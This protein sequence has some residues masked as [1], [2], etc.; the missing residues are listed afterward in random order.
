MPRHIQHIRS[1]GNGGGSPAD[2]LLKPS[3]AA[4]AGRCADCQPAKRQAASLRYKSC[5]I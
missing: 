4:E 1:T 3:H 2:A 5:A